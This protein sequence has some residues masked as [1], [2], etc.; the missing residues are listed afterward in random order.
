MGRKSPVVV[1]VRPPISS[2]G[3]TAIAGG[4]VTHAERIVIRMLARRAARKVLATA[5]V[6]KFREPTRK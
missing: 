3:D 5:P 6:S 4:P 2:N 1:S